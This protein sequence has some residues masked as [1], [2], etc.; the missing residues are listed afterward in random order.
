[1]LAANYRSVFAEHHR[2]I[3]QM[4]S[5]SH[6]HGCGYTHAAGLPEVQVRMDGI[7][8]SSAPKHVKCLN[9]LRN[10]VNG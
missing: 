4:Q 3:V 8:G 6:S 2:E 9:S 1:V 5:S 10:S 7:L